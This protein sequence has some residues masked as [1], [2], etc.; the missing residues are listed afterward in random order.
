M[1]LI[2]NVWVRE[3]WVINAG[4]W[5]FFRDL[6]KK[7]IA[8]DPSHGIKRSSM[9]EHPALFLMVKDFNKVN[10]FNVNR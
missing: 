7:I 10:Y 6:L 5:N 4:S 3:G 2:Y 8:V 9:A 1:C